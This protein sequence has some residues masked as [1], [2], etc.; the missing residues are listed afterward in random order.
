VLHLATGPGNV[1][2]Q[3]QNQHLLGLRACC[4]S[5]PLAPRSK[6]LQ[7]LQAR[8]VQVSKESSG[9]PKLRQFRWATWTL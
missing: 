6:T 3:C 4:S 1:P 9:L 5:P 7:Q 8:E 2:V